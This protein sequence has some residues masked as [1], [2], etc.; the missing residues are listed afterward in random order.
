LRE[1]R[2][3]IRK[4][5][6]KALRVS[7][8]SPVLRSISTARRRTATRTSQKTKIPLPGSIHFQKPFVFS[9]AITGDFFNSSCRRRHQVSSD[10]K[11]QPSLAEMISVGGGEWTDQTSE[12]CSIG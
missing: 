12:I 6:S 4:K 1:G 11:I 8:S 5:I 3:K 7:K 10:L 2:L 9:S